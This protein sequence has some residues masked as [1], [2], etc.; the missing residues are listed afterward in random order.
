MA[1]QPRA[2]VNPTDEPFMLYRDPPPWSAL[3][4]ALHAMRSEDARRREALKAAVAMRSSDFADIDRTKRKGAEVKQQLE[5]LVLKRKQ[6]HE[7][8]GLPQPTPLATRPAAATVNPFK[9]KAKAG[10]GPHDEPVA[11][12]SCGKGL[13]PISLVPTPVF[14]QELLDVSAKEN[15]KAAMGEKG[16]S[17]LP[18]KSSRRSS[19]PSSTSKRKQPRISEPPLKKAGGFDWQK[20][21]K[22]GP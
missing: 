22:G 5:N 12:T 6:M 18:S 10:I 8:F 15:K 20:W 2:W 7:D 19:L 1:G 13:V 17:Q 11:S 9:R 16:S 21:G 4:D 14:T 3:A